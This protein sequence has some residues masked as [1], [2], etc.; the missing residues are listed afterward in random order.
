M[1]EFH[2]VLLEGIFTAV[3]LVILYTILLLFSKLLLKYVFKYSSY[4]P[5]ILY[6]SLMFISAILLHIIFE[7]TGLNKYYVDNYS[8]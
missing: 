8:K 6:V 1:K 5:M 3:C 4:K 2:K 7:Y